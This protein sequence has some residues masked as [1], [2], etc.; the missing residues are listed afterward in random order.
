MMQSRVLDD[1]FLFLFLFIHVFH[2]IKSTGIR[3]H[4]LIEN[5]VALS[6]CFVTKHYLS[7]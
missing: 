4:S 6:T 1:Q 5:A 7:S 3:P 2:D